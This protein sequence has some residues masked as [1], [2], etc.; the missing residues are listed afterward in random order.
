MISVLNNSFQNWIR[1]ISGNAFTVMIFRN[2]EKKVFII[3][4]VSLSLLIILSFSFN[5][6]LSIDKTLSERNEVTV[7][8]N[9]LSS[10]MS[11][12]L[13]LLYQFFFILFNKET[14]IRLFR[15]LFAIFIEPM[16][17]K[18]VTEFRPM[19]YY[20]AQF[21]IH[22]RKMITTNILLFKWYLLMQASHTY[23]YKI[24]SFIIPGICQR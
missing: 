19:H 1:N 9:F 13:R 5:F 6:I 23:I 16:S 10:V 18:I 2:T 12:S 17:Q 22:K 11:F 8:Q 3:L 20:L 7:F 15:I 14:V 24:A 4:A 21:L